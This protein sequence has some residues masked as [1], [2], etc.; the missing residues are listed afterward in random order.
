MHCEIIDRY[1]KI[2]FAEIQLKKE[3]L[4]GVFLVPEFGHPNQYTKQPGYIT[5][6]GQCYNCK[7]SFCKSFLIFKTMQHILCHLKFIIKACACQFFLFHQMIAL[8]KLWKILFI[9]S[10]S[11]F[12]SWD[13]QF[14]PFLDSK[15]QVKVE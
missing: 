1:F 5:A 14:L 10:R 11:S 7:Y 15:G 4:K 13:I 2:F 6:D 3:T 8:Q 9:P 12:R